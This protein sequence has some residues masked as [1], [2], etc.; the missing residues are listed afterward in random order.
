MKKSLFTIALL[1]ILTSMSSTAGSLAKAKA[2]ETTK[3]TM[4]GYIT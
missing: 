3:E 1:T 4:P 2:E